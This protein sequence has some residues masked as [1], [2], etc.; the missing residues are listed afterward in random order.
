MFRADVGGSGS[1]VFYIK[2]LEAVTNVGPG[3]RVRYKNLNNDVTGF[4]LEQ[5]LK[6]MPK[7]R[8]C[9]II[10]KYSFENISS[11]SA[12]INTINFTDVGCFGVSGRKIFN[13]KAAGA[14]SSTA[15]LSLRPLSMCC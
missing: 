6:S 12:G 13:I 11:D 9:N 15:G 1:F 14:G 5:Q 10:L 4:L 3:P 7:R 8:I 2:T